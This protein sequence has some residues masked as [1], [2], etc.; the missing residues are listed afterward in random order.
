MSS[1]ANEVL[2]STGG[3][4]K[5]NNSGSAKVSSYT[6]QEMGDIVLEQSWELA[7]QV[8]SIRVL[9]DPTVC[10][11]FKSSA[12]LLVTL[13]D[14]RVLMLNS[15]S[16]SSGS[17]SST[18]ESTNTLNSSTSSF[19]SLFNATTSNIPDIIE[20]ANL[21]SIKTATAATTPCAMP[22][23]LFTNVHFNKQNNYSFMV[24]SDG[25][26]FFFRIE[27][28]KNVREYIWHRALGKLI[29]N[30]FKIDI[31]VRSWFLN[32]LFIG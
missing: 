15:S 11:S 16:G 31:N 4:S 5:L 2:S 23:F 3:N 26:V 19:S 28:T 13:S 9:R 30:Q 27:A 29:I 14:T 24:T 25:E 20:V 10:S 7:D 17:S 18:A 12:F 1:L 32:V 21:N 8:C 22:C 6:F